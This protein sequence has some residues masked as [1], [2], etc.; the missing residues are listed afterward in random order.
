[1]TNVEYLYNALSHKL[2]APPPNFALEGGCGSVFQ[3]RRNLI[4]ISHHVAILRRFTNPRH[5]NVG[6][7]VP[8]Q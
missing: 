7:F 3:L 5:E 2:F 6:W 4:A 8:A 1:M